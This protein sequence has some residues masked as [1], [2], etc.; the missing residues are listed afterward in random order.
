[1]IVYPNAKINLG[2]EIVGR[3][4]DGYHLLDSL[5]CPIALCDVLEL[6]PGQ[7]DGD[8]LQVYGT[9]DPGILED[10][11]VLRA[12]RALRRHVDFPWVDLYL[13]KHIPSG[14]GMGGGSSDATFALRAIRELFALDLS[15]DELRKVALELGADCPFF[16]SNRTCLVSGIGEIY[17]D[18]PAELSLGDLGLVVV[19]PPL[20]VATRSAFSGLRRIG[21]Q[22]RS[23]AEVL[24]LPISQWRAYLHNAF[25]DSLF[26]IYPELARI[27]QW[28]Y[29]QG[30]IYASMTG[31]GSALYGFYQEPI[32]PDRL[33]TFPRDYF[34]WQGRVL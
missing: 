15:D 19:K 28:L 21:G 18:A 32:S 10:N 24:A 8:T 33:G 3:R 29:D 20:H 25:E 4:A 5:F 7:S 31:S 1:M 6:H 17:S 30:A 34:V 23:V 14:A 16:V 22:E 13:Y 27:K 2:L 9:E 12:V 26:P 11:L